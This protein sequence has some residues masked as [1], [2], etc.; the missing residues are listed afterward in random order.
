[1]SSAAGFDFLKGGALMIACAL[2]LFAASAAFGWSCRRQSRLLSIILLS[3]QYCARKRALLMRG[4]NPTR[5]LK[6]DVAVLGPCGLHRELCG[7]AT[8]NFR[9][10]V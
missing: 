10:A 6:L 7:N 5:C 8:T 2:M 3:V 4:E 9:I 1:M